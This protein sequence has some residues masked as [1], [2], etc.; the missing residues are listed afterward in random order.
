MKKGI[1]VGIASAV[2]LMGGAAI[3]ST[4][5]ASQE[6][7]CGPKLLKGTYSFLTTGFG[8]VPPQEF[9]VT[10]VGAGGVLL[11][12]HA[13]GH[14]EFKADGSNKGYIHENVGGAL[15]DNVPFVG[16]TS[17]WGSGPGGVGCQATWK[18]QDSHRLPIFLNEPAHFFKIA[19]GN[20]RFEFVTF[21]G[22]PA[23]AVLSGFAT[24]V[25]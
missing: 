12:L 10:P 11:P 19:L 21:G 6:P 20:D 14:V 5:S 18:L 2:T 4:N 7:V 17:D 9:L 3:V 13:I 25:K 16:T 22:G 24:K 15:E 1:L 23:P 8:S